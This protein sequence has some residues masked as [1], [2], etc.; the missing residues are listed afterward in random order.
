MP[1]HLPDKLDPDYETLLINKA[2]DKMFVEAQARFDFQIKVLSYI[3]SAIKWLT[4][5]GGV[6]YFGIK[7]RNL[8]QW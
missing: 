7:N 1:P 6:I 8:F 3:C 2:V 5:L 4:I